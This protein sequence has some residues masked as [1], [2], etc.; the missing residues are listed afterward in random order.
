VRVRGATVETTSEI[1]YAFVRRI[2]VRG[3]RVVGVYGAFGGAPDFGDGPITEG[4]VIVAE[5]RAALAFHAAAVLPPP[6]GPSTSQALAVG[7]TSSG[8][9]VV[10]N[11]NYYE[12]GA[13]LT[14][15][16]QLVLDATAGGGFYGSEGTDLGV[17]ILAETGLL[18]LGP[19]AR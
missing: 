9:T 5:H 14:A 16:H 4:S 7:A 19:P 15:T 8:A 11:D 13:D 6:M 18:E 10:A 17:R 2:D 3:E 1:A 12:L